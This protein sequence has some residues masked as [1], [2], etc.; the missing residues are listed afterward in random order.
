LGL[1]IVKSLTELHN[2]TVDVQSGG[3]GQGSTFSVRLPIA[4][5]VAHEVSIPH[6]ATPEPQFD[7][8]T[9]LTGLRILVVDDEMDARTLTQRVLEESGAQVLTACSTAE[10]LAIVDRNNVLSVIVSDIG[11]P[12]QDGYDLIKQMR[13]LPGDAGRVPAIAL[14]ALAR[15]DDRKRALLAGYQ[16]H[17]SKPVNPAELVAVVANL[18]GRTERASRLHC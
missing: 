12:D 10:A 8:A 17:V 1:S 6:P 16:T 11:M 4:H 2:G 5:P 14:T 9:T 7:P 15:A 18:A 3:Q 13:A